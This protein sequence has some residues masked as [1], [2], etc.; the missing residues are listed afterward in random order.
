MKSQT[1]Q[2][3]V[4][5]K[6]EGASKRPKVRFGRERNKGVWPGII[7]WNHDIFIFWRASFQLFFGEISSKLG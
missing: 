6:R 1:S 2:L 5:G 3:K 7:A 4:P